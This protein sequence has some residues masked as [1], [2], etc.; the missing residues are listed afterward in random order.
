MPEIEPGEAV[1]VD[2]T[3]EEYF[4]DTSALTRSS[5]ALFAEDPE[6]FYRRWE[7]G[8]REDAE[9]ESKALTRGTHSHLAILEPAEW[10]RRVG[11]PEVPRPPGATGNGRKGSP[12]LESYKRWREAAELRDQLMAALPDRIDVSLADYARIQAIAQRVWTHHEAAT[13]LSAPG[14]NE[15]TVLWR[16]PTTGLLVKVR[17]DALRDLEPELVFGSKGLVPGPAI[18]DLKTT[19]NPEPWAFGR[20]IADHGYDDQAAIYSDAVEALIGQRPTY[21]IVAVRNDGNHKTVVGRIPEAAIERSRERYKARLI[22]L[23]ERRFTGDWSL[24]YETGVI[25]FPVPD[26]KRRR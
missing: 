23:L 8:E 10:N 1:A 3:A 25:E 16:E 12:E 11:I 6:K 7:L 13:L 9:H 4:A 21:Y 26:R 24:P 22:E 19:R 17:I 20:D 14:T 5:L 18:L 15:Q 2:W